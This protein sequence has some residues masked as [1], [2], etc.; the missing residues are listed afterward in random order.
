MSGEEDKDSKTHEASEQ[1]IRKAREKGDVPISKEVGHVLAL[2]SFSFVA[3]LIFG[4]ALPGLADALGQ[5]FLA[6][7]LDV[8]GDG[9]DGVS[10]LLMLMGAPLIQAGKFFALC[11][12]VMAAG[13]LV[14]A[15]LQGPFVVSTERIMPKW[16]KLSPLKGIKKIFG[17]DNLVEFGKNLVKLCLIVILSLWIVWGRLDGMLPGGQAL[18]ESIPGL[19][20]HDA[21]RILMAICLITIPI[22]VFDNIWKRMSFAKK[23]RMSQKELKDE[24]KQSE[25]DPMVK[26][27]RMQLA[28]RRIARPIRQAVPEATIIITNPT[29]FAVALRY[30]RGVDI[31]PVCVAKGTDLAAARIRAIAHEHEIPVMENR[32]LA[33]ALF[34]GAELDQPIPEEHWPLVADLIGYIMALRQRIRRPLPPDTVMRED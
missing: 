21:L 27:K 30:V 5:L 15:M 34:A 17:K 24:H 6:P 4:R 11:L 3:A 2:V 12:S 23:Q 28:R 7:Q 14:A 29:H 25:G 32:P 19:L 31:A 18:P 13:A 33:R 9:M 20:R 16:N 8:I 22:A 26:A 1:K 10:D